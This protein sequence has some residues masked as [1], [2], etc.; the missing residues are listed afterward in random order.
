MAAK[1]GGIALGLN[2]G[3]EGIQ[4]PPG[5]EPEGVLLIQAVYRR[6][7]LYRGEWRAR[8]NQ[9]IMPQPAVQIHFTGMRF[10]IA[11]PLDAAQFLQPP[12]A[13]AA[14]HRA[15]RAQLVPYGFGVWLAPVMAKTPRQIVDDLGIVAHALRRRHG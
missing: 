7:D 2:S 8:T 14:V 5:G 9:R 3:I 15:Q 4:A 13:H 11:G 6:L 12:V 10:V 1:R